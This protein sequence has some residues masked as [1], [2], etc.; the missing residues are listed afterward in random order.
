[1][2]KLFIIIT[3]LSLPSTALEKFSFSQKQ[4]GCNFRVL[5][6]SS[7][8]NSAQNAANNAFKRIEEINQICSD[9]IAHSEI[10]KISQTQNQW[11]R[12]SKDL[13]NI[14]NYSQKLSQKTDG[15]FDVTC[16][17]LTMMWRKARFMK[18]LPSEIQIKRNLERCGYRKIEIKNQQIKLSKR[19]AI[20]T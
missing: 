10:S 17:P 6:F 7:N 1:M 12:L 13:S 16:G 9:Y 2:T 11:I 3:L 14:L 8:H 19:I 18:K 4:M 15:A 5:V 20:N